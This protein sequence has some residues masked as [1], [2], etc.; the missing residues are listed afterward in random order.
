VHWTPFDEEIFQGEGNLTNWIKF[1]T[2]LNE[3]GPL[4]L[5]VIIS[6]MFIEWW[7]N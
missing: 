5:Q 4:I 2:W 3:I 6:S 1:M 7:E